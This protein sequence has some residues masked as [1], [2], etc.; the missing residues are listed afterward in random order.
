M[1][2]ATKALSDGVHSSYCPQ[3]ACEED[4]WTIA[5]GSEPWPDVCHALSAGL[6]GDRPGCFADGGPWSDDTD[7]KAGVDSMF[8]A[9]LSAM[10]EAVELVEPGHL[11]EIFIEPSYEDRT[12]AIVLFRDSLLLRLEEKAWML[13]FETLEELDAFMAEHVTE[14][15]A[16]YTAVATPL[17]DG[18][19][20]SRTRHAPLCPFCR[21]DANVSVAYENVDFDGTMVS[22]KASCGACDKVWYD[23]YQLSGYEAEEE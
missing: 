7:T 11:L 2:P 16:R 20:V 10:L 21:A 23:I 4:L 9:V 8:Y 1:H 5:D 14:L 18:E 13:H 19:Y 12:T 3:G 6:K 17:T 15:Q 22:Q